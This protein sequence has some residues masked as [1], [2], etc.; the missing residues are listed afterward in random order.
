MASRTYKSEGPI[1]YG[2]YQFGYCEWMELSAR[3]SPEE[4]YLKGFLPYSADPGQPSHLFYMA[5]SLRVDL[6][7]FRLEKKRRYDH[8]RWAAWNLRRTVM[9]KADFL[10]N[11]GP[12]ARIKAHRWMENRFGDA[13]LKQDRLQYIL[14]KPFLDDILVWTDR[15]DLTGFALIV[16]GHWGA[17]YWYVFYLNDPGVAAPPGHGYLV[18]FIDW[19]HH[20]GLSHAYL[21]TA[22]G[23]KSLYKS[24]GIEGIEFWNGN[25]WD[26]D[27]ERLT[28]LQNIDE[29]GKSPS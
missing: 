17:H 10:E 3:E 26:N 24:R 19:C 14:E 20:T 28:L 5:R 27:R 29:T 16:K 13:Y 12:V 1:H 15:E 2:R 6:Q 22:Y 25:R 8:R 21:G 18:D 11:Y 4:P 23:H 9:K 7:R